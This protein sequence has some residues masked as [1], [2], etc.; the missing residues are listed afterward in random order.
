M[1][2]IGFMFYVCATIGALSDTVTQLIIFRAP[3][4]MGVAVGSVAPITIIGD[5]FEGQKRGRSMG[6]Y[7]MLVALGPGLGPVVGGIVGQHYGVDHLFWLLF[8]VSLLFW[9]IL[10]LGLPETWTPHVNGDNFGFSR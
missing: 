7:Q 5:L 9:L 8:A 10:F 4:A 6:I 2:L 3:Q 1:L